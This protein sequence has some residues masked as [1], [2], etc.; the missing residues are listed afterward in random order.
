MTGRPM[1]GFVAVDGKSLAG[2]A[3]LQAW[4]DLALAFVRTL[5]PKSAKPAKPRRGR[6]AGRA[7]T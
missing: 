5:P 1:E 2:D 6:G 7:P 3:D 4:I